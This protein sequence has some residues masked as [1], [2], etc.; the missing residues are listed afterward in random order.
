MKK[1]KSATLTKSEL[2]SLT[3]LL[4]EFRDWL[5]AGERLRERI[6][7]FLN[8]IEETRLAEWNPD[9]IKWTQAEGSR[10]PYERADKQEGRDFKLLLKDLDEH[11]GRM[12]KG[13]Y[14]YWRFD[15]SETVGRKPRRKRQG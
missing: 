13:A 12:T 7:E 6:D 10:G 11:G 15:Q 5:Q 4:A 14:F 9:N 8:L 3:E 2:Q 1:L